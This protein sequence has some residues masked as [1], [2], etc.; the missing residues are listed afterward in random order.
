MGMPEAPVE[1][2]TE[3]PVVETPVVETP[4]VETPAATVE[5]PVVE[6]PAAAQEPQVIEKVVEKIVEKYPELNDD[7]KWL[8]EAIQNDKEDD[9][10]SYLSERKKDYKTM[11]AL[12]V[13]REAL[14]KDNP[15]WSKDEIELEVRF[16]YG[17]NLEKVDLSTIDK[18]LQPKEFED[19]V[20][21][22]AEVERNEMALNRDARDARIKLSELQKTIKL[23]K[24]KQEEPAPVQANQPT[25]EQVEEAK[26][27]WEAAIDTEV[28]KLADLKFNVGDD[29]N[30][31]E[32]VFKMTDDDRKARVE[33]MKGWTGDQFMT[34]RGWKNEDGTLNVLKIAEDV[35]T[36]E[37]LSK[38]VK[39][40]YSQAAVA[41]TKGVIAKE[42]KN[43]D[44]EGERSQG[45]QGTPADV[46]A[47]LWG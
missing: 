1:Q 42:I 11:A 15:S 13:V 8:L 3:A 23:P 39:S 17:N 21:H 36:L 4:V 28:V 12:D 41:A 33:A 7:Q 18:D 44:F 14:R 46:G 10:Y 19:A 35:H 9:I 5:T 20:R 47:L 43:I 16:K 22:N 6:P 32:V 25:P 26:K 27:K 34:Q 45:T 2:Q 30:P 29:K 24:I 37:N 31:E 40:V 38:I